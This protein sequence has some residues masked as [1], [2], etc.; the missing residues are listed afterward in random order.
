MPRYLPIC[1]NQIRAARAI[2]RWS[3]KDLSR[4]SGVEISA[5]EATEAAGDMYDAHDGVVITLSIAFLS[6]T[7]RFTPGCGVEYPYSCRWKRI[8][9]LTPATCRAAR[10]LIGWRQDQLSESAS[11]NRLTIAA[12]ERGQDGARMRRVN[13]DP[14]MHTFERVGLEFIP[15]NGAGVLEWTGVRLRPQGY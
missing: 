1:G 2:L 3:V 7:V 12:Y 6:H 13:A 15:T 14:V 5:I 8:N 10:A 4:A 11:V 9:G